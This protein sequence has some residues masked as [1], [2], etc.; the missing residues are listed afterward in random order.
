MAIYS[1]NHKS[2]GKA[3][4][5][6]AFTAAAHIRYIS[7]TNACRA[8]LG[9]RLPSEP[10][11][12]QR[13]MKVEEASDRKNA[14]ICEKV[15]IALPRELN[16]AQRVELVR[17][18]AERVTQGKAPWLAAVHDKGKD[19]SNPHCH[20]VFRDRDTQTGRRVL[21]MSAGKSERALLKE[22][23]IDAMTTDRM[24]VIWEHAANEHLERAEFSERIDHRS[25][26]AQGI[27]RDPT[28]HEGVKAKQMTARGERPQS[29]VVAFA[30]A[31]TARSGKRLVDYR[32]LDDG[33][34]RQ[35]YNASIVELAE[36]RNKKREK[37][38]VRNSELRDTF[39]HELREIRPGARRRE[40]RRTEKEQRRDGG[41]ASNARGA[42]E[43]AERSGQHKR[44]ASDREHDAGNEPLSRTQSQGHRTVRG[45]HG[46]P[47]SPGM[48]SQTNQGGRMT[49]DEEIFNKHLSRCDRDEDR[50]DFLKS[51]YRD[52][53]EQ[54][55]A[56]F[57]EYE[58][59]VKTM[60]ETR[61][62]NEAA[63]KVRDFT[64][65]ELQK[66]EAGREFLFK[67]APEIQKEIYAREDE[68]QQKA[69]EVQRDKVRIFLNKNRD[70]DIGG[71][72]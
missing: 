14:R 25:L 51:T 53:Y 32:K 4:Q 63:I 39:A 56:N 22:Q 28:I 71:R 8:F 67:E 72:G 41:I 54:E 46:Q 30:N 58:R 33:S 43:P 48:F 65:K 13:W 45:V 29:K 66:T 19:Q 69:K 20:L 49:T 12:A 18:F 16:A 68:R 52:T 27:E 60:D 34:T 6:R 38:I 31:P 64:I 17:D 15:M 2:I 55:I 10:G 57:G 37:E 23:G 59:G 47:G 40:D 62:A 61:T 3:T 36:V 44:D 35:E 42:M 7:R 24:R 9:N 1:L 70:K 50:A 11:K 21:H 5:E 26:E